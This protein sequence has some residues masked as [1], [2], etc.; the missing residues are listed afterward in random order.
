MAP[1]CAP[2]SAGLHIPPSGRVTRLLATTVD[3]TFSADCDRLLVF[4]D[5][6]APGWSATIDGAPVPV[7]RVNNAIRAVMAPAG[8]HSLV[9]HYRPRFLGPLLALLALGLGASTLLIAAPWWLRWLPLRP[10]S[11]IDH[12]FG[13]N[14]VGVPSPSVDHPQ[15]PGPPV[16]PAPT[17]STTGRSLP[18]G[19]IA[20]A[21]T[22]IGG[23]TIASLALYDANI[24]GPSDPFRRFLVR[25]II[26][27]AWAWVTVAGHVGFASPV[28]PVLLA[29]VLLPALSLQA[30]R[31]A[32]P[33]TSGAPV[34]EIAS[35]FRSAS[36]QSAWEVV[37]RGD[38]PASG[39]DGTQLRNDGS[40]AHAVT[41]TLPEPSSALWAWWQRPLGANAVAPSYV[42]SWTATI[43]RS[44]PY[45]TV[46]KLGRLTIQVLKAGILITAPA[47]GGD[48]TGDFIEGT[49]PNG[50]PNSWQI[51]TD[52]ASTTLSLNSE[53][54]WTGGSAGTAQ[55][56]ALGDASADA[57]HRGIMTITSA[58]VTLRMAILSR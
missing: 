3:V 4:T 24:D 7:L 45:Y 17:P 35:D 20:L 19:G 8:E 37:G 55:A 9:W 47:P 6:W 21:V 27:G 32:D 44:G 36:W 31:H 5:S 56:V 22:A 52:P 28:G 42:V 13:L 34:H 16:A 50:S 46:L 29:V 25:S 57:E 12:L 54:V 1:D 39:P 41:H 23:A 26:A 10:S 14:H 30:A 15:L 53:R 2:Q 18:I 49:S 11:H 38:G 51:T 48:V 33:I 43:E 40:T 58:S